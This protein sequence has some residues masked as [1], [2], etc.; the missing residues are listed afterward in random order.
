MSAVNVLVQAKAVH[1]LTDGAAYLADRSLKFTGTKILPFPHL[2]CAIAVRGPALAVPLLCTIL[3]HASSYCQLR[4]EAAQALQGAA[5]TYAPIFS[6]CDLGA[7]FEVVVGG[8]D[9]EGNPDAFL[10]ASHDRYGNEPWALQSLSGIVCLPNDTALHER[11]MTVLATCNGPD[12]VDP[13]RHG[14]E[15]IEL[16]RSNPLAQTDGDNK[17]AIGGFC[18]LTTIKADAIVT[19]VIRRWPD[20]IGETLAA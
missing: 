19:R 12:D 5:K 3:N 20:R 7:D 14:L 17:C 13:V 16:Q 4:D 6:Q 9:D 18:Q 1:I 11:I 8:V 15:I 2:G 10:V